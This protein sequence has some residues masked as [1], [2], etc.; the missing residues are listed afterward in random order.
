MAWVAYLIPVDF[1]TGIMGRCPDFRRKAQIMTI[2]NMPSLAAVR[3]ILDSDPLLTRPTKRP[4]FI[5][6]TSVPSGMH[7]GAPC[8]SVRITDQCPRMGSQPLP[9]HCS[10]TGTQDCPSDQALID[11]CPTC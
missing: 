10:V 1:S 5:D 3:E 6:V 11:N 9:D 4:E 2:V 8:G 7:V